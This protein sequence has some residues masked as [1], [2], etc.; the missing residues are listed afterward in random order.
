VF[1]K[2]KKRTLLSSGDTTMVREQT[3]CFILQEQF[4][5]ET[6]CNGAA[7]T[8]SYPYSLLSERIQT[9]Y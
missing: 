6:H 2:I 8:L 7:F 4:L 5:G 1:G 3:P 9:R